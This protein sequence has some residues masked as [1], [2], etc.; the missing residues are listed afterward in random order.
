[1][2]ACVCVYLC[3]NAPCLPCNMKFKLFFWKLGTDV[4][5]AYSQRYLN[6][7]HICEHYTHKNIRYPGG[8][9]STMAIES[10]ILRT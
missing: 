2:Y 8:N 6:I 3:L 4:T 5:Q 1:M 10:A 9:L 7:F